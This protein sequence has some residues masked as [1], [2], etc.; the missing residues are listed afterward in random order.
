MKI[1]RT[2]KG[3]P[4]F[5]ESGGSYTNTGE[6]TIITGKDGQ[7]KKAIYVRRRG[8]LANGE[9]ALIPIEVG[10]H[11]IFASHHNGDFQIEIFRITGFE[12]KE[13]DAHAVIEQVNCFD[14]NEWDAELPA[15][16]HAA[17]EA[18]KNKAICYHCRTPHFIAQYRFCAVSRK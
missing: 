8:E 6:A 9:H 15:Y 16:L 3:H 10:D 4:A 5:W 7:P 17:V 14:K 11:I 1:E 2:K 18:A 12:D 13:G